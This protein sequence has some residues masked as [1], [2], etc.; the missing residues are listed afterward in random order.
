MRILHVAA[1]IAPIAKVG[2][3]ADV[4]YGLS[5]AQIAEGHEVAVLIPK[6]DFI[7]LKV[8]P[9][10]DFTCRFDG[11][12]YNNTL[13]KGELDGI[14]LLLI[15][16]HHPR[17]WFSRGAVYVA[18]DDPERFL[19]FCRAAY[20]YLRKHDMPEVLHM[21]DWQIGPL[22][23][24][25]KDEAKKVTTIHNFFHQGQCKSSLLKLIDLKAG[26]DI[27]D[28]AD[29]RKVNLLKAGIVHSD[30]VNTVSPTY[31]KEVMT[32]QMGYG[33]EKVLKKYSAKFSGI[34]NGIDTEY[35]NPETDP[36]LFHNYTHKKL[37]ERKKA[38]QALQEELNLDPDPDKPI[39]AAITRLVPQ[40]GVDLL[41]HIA[42]EA[43][44]MGAQFLLLG[45]SPFPKV[46]RDFEKLA[47]KHRKSGSLHF[48]LTYNETLSHQVY[49]GADMLAV[50]SLFEPCGLTQLIA[51]R[52][53]SVPIV[54]STGGLADTVFE[55]ENGFT[56]KD[57]SPRAFKSAVKRA[58]TLW[59]E[60]P[61]EWRKLMV[62]GMKEDNSWKA[63][64]RHYLDM[65][66]SI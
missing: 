7:D 66:Q 59:K 64:A 35:W 36:L 47:D 62:R 3:L 63:A 24:L 15:E 16:A 11:E 26:S 13:W 28:G 57:S 49:A 17:M 14:P 65:Y 6:Y 54:R 46:Q 43:P 4:I 37:K 60:D 20:D 8:S 34:L 51:L 12:E 25:V 19:Y 48:E 32:S 29:P 39:L 38:R 23:L 5:R 30:R 27:L 61:A 58:F 22:S 56:F 1:E 45:S 42:E 2:G 53:G 33:L 52:Y 21:H 9:V 41:Y 10:T 44:K 40:K 50:P 18:E 31:A 55:G